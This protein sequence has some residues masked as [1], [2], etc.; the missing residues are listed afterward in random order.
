MDEEAVGFKRRLAELEDQVAS[1]PR[2]VLPSQTLQRQTSS[3]KLREE[4]N[5]M[6]LH[7]NQ[8]EEE[9]FELRVASESHEPELQTAVPVS[10]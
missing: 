5:K 8:L 9:V 1:A 4:C 2:S 6:R 7:M 3:E 10:A